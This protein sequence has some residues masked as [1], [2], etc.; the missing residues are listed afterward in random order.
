[1]SRDSTVFGGT[2][3]AQTAYAGETPGWYDGLMRWEGTRGSRVARERCIF[4][5][6]IMGQ[7][8]PIGNS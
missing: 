5:S 3:P 6:L 4:S 8:D 2:R 7:Y 1:M